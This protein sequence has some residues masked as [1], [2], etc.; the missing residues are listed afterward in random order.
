[1]L[2]NWELEEDYDSDYEENEVAGSLVDAQKVQSS[3]Q[4]SQQNRGCPRAS[5]EPTRK[6]AESRVSEA[7]SHGFYSDDDSDLDAE[8]LPAGHIVSKSIECQDSSSSRMKALQNANHE[9]IGKRIHGNIDRRSRLDGAEK[10]NT[11]SIT[12]GELREAFDEILHN[13]TTGKSTGGIN[14]VD[15]M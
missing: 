11:E 15:K 2:N 7:S 10:L 3:Q 14:E 8:E 1:M 9:E 12:I 6:S 5:D 13:A 4:G